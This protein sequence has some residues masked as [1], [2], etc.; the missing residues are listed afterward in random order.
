MEEQIEYIKLTF[1]EIDNQIA[2]LIKNEKLYENEMN[3]PYVNEL[4]VVVFNITKLL[5]TLID[6]FYSQSSYADVIKLLQASDPFAF[7]YK[8]LRIKPPVVSIIFQ[9]SIGTKFDLI[10]RLALILH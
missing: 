1:R 4:K 3:G 9:D 8:I 7:L 2:G 6:L 5:S 10:H